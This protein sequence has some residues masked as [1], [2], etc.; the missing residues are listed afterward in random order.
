MPGDEKTLIDAAVQLAEVLPPELLYRLSDAIS[1]SDVTDWPEAE[2]RILAVTPQAPFRALVVQYLFAWRARVSAL[3]ASAAALALRAAAAISQ[4]YRATQRLDLVWTGPDVADIP[5]RRTEQALLEVIAAAERELLIVSFAVY[6]IPEITRALVQAFERG[7]RLRICVEAPE[8]EGEK[9][10]YDTI[11]A[12]GREVQQCAAI[13]IWPRDQRLQSAQGKSGSLHA[14]C[15]VA[16]DK[17]LFISSANLTEYAMQLNMEMGVL[18][19]GS[20][21]PG[22]VVHHFGRLIEGGLLQRV[23]MF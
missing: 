2:R 17:L 21:L 23:E 22:I 11:R 6:R 19:Q 7:V 8:P 13:Y 10:A 12:L 16:D 3:P 15:A 9:I 18:I 20:T 1:A 4:H 14:K 5:L